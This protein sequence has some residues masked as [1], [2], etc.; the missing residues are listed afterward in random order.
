M[1][2]ATQLRFKNLQP[3]D[4]QKQV[5]LQAIEE[6]ENHTPENTVVKARLKRRGKN[7]IA[8]IRVYSGKAFFKAEMSGTSVREL[9]N[10]LRHNLVLQV[11]KWKEARRRRKK[12]KTHRALRAEK[13]RLLKSNFAETSF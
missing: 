3:T 2:A 13:L 5:L 10:Q 6:I 8:K 1:S 11:G 7:F 9:A 12:E 4:A